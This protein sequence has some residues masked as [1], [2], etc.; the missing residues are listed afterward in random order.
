MLIRLST[1]H[2]GKVSSSSPA[3]TQSAAVSVVT[4]THQSSVTDTADDALNTKDLLRLLAEVNFIY[5]EVKSEVNV[6]LYT[7]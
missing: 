4:S 5:G 2:V 6:D 7:T 3:S 1:G